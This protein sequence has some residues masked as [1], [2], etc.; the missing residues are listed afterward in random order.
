MKKVLITG[1]NSYVGNAVEAHLLQYPD[2]YQVDKV[3][4]RTN[5]W[6][7]MDFSIYD[8]VIHVAGIAHVSRKKS[9]KDKYFQINRDLTVNVAKKAKNEGIHQ[10]IFMSSMIVYSSKETRITE[11]TLPNPDNFYGQ[12]KLEAE[13]LLSELNDS[14]F[15]VS[16]IR[17]PMIYGPMAKGNYLKLSNLARKTPIFPRYPNQRSMIFIENLNLYV[18]ELIKR[19]NQGVFHPQNKETVNTSEL[20][21]TIANIH[22]KK[23]FQTRLFNLPIKAM[24]KINKTFNKLFGDYYYAID[25]DGIMSSLK[26]VD[27]KTSVQR[28]ERG[29]HD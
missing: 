4:L 21:K 20:V 22:G 25:H 14:S 26:F 7:S 17:P 28:T 11:N 3:S 5:E 8:V 24:V 19:N 10:F 27:F 6:Q 9:L 1:K 13:Q 2:A 29:N 18:R 16:I 12:S 15:I 23:Q